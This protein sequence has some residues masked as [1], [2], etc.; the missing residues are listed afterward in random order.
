MEEAPASAR[1]A[2]AAYCFMKTVT[3]GFLLASGP[4]VMTLLVSV[5]PSAESVQVPSLSGFLV[6]QSQ[7]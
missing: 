1:F 3:E 5:F 7:S 2:V 4:N 6:A